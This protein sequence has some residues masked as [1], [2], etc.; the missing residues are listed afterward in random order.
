MIGAL[1]RRGFGNK[2]HMN[3]EPNISV[4][5]MGSDLDVTT[6]P[7]VRRAIDAAVDGGCLRIIL[8]MSG[9]SYVD[10][11]GMGLIVSELRSLRGR[12]GLLSLTNVSE[13]VYHSLEIMRLLD[14][15]PVSVR[16]H[17]VTELDPSV[18]PLWRT[19][20][21]VHGDGLTE[22]RG[23]VEELLGSMVTLSAA[24]IYGPKQ[25]GLLWT[26]DDVRLRPLVLGGGQE[27]GVR[28]GTEN[29]AGVVGF[30]RAM[31]LAQ[32]CRGEESRRL[33][34]LRGR[35]EEGLSSAF[36]CRWRIPRRPRGRNSTAP[37]GPSRTICVVAW[38][39]GSCD[40]IGTI[41]SRGKDCRK[42]I[43]EEMR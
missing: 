32:D 42:R 15:M 28:S 18:L 33:E 3:S 29:V 31:V 22:A 17:R 12:G 1:A 23:R 21:R 6:V 30:A 8:N 37:S 2:P 24:K 20:L 13:R 7:R 36:P 38:M 43:Q 25:V 5:T 9:A 19:T 16:G 39:A 4:L 40:N 26:S 11:A 34:T 35:L 27:N 14:Q 41:V 10:S